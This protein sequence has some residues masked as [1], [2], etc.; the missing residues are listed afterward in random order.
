MIFIWVTVL[1]D[2]IRAVSDKSFEALF[3]NFANRAN[4]RRRFTGTKIT[5]DL[6]APNWKSEVS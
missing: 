5:T 1:F 4:F 2:A 6:T 3:F